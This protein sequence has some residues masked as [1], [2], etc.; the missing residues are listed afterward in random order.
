MASSVCCLTTISSPM[1]HP[2]EERLKSPIDAGAGGFVVSS[3]R[4]RLLPP[5]G[6]A[7]HVTGQ[8]CLATSFVWDCVHKLKV[9]KGVTVLGRPAQLVTKLRYVIGTAATIPT[10]SSSHE[11]PPPPLLEL[12]LGEL[13]VLLV[14]LGLGELVVLMLELGHVWQVV[15]QSVCTMYANSGPLGEVMS[16]YSAD[17]LLHIL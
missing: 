10:S 13:L 12:G 7:S 9:P 16:A 6:Q 11:A 2:D 3:S 8:F 17:S 4:R 15:E 5:L 14:E 1:R